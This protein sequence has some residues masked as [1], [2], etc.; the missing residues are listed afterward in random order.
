MNSVI[1]I[2]KATIPTLRVGDPRDPSVALGPLVNRA[3]YERVQGFIRRGEEQGATLIVGGEGRPDGLEKGYFVKPTVFA[4]VRNN[5][6]LARE[7]IFG[8]VLSILTYED[9]DEAIQ[10]AI[11]SIYGL[12]AYV[13]SSHRERANQIASRLEAGTV[14]VNG[15][16]PELLAPFGGFKQSGIGREFGVFGLEAFLEPKTLVLA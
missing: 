15:I 16:R 9:E 8:S 7:E 4:N 10:I 11:D 13:F 5:M 1:E 2:V 3:Q 6:E 12:Q 14:L